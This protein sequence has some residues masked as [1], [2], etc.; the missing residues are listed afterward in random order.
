MRVFAA[1]SMASTANTCSN[2]KFWTIVFVLKMSKR[3]CS[4]QNRGLE[5]YETKS[6][7]LSVRWSPEAGWNGSHVPKSHFYPRPAKGPGTKMGLQVIMNAS[8]EDYFCSST[9]S[10][11][12]KVL[13]HSPDETP[14]LV[15]NFAVSVSTAFESRMMVTPRVNTASPNIRSISLNAR[16]CAFEDEVELEYFQ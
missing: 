5:T 10:A 1:C 11:G 14:M 16:D 9:N 12:F 2:R 8:V 6:N 15:D 7:L 4:V 13:V 3:R